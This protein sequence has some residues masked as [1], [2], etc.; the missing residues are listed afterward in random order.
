MTMYIR[1]INTIDDVSAAHWNELHDNRNPFVTHEFL[2]SLEREQCV[3]DDTGWEPR[4][5]I[6]EQEDQPVG[7]IPMYLKYHSMGEFVF[8]WAWAGAY[9]RSGLD[10]YPKLVIAIPYTPVTGPRLLLA[11]SPERNHIAE[12]MIDFALQYA[13][14]QEVSSMHWLF[15]NESDSQRLQRHGLLLRTDCQFHWKNAGYSSFDDFLSRLSSHKRKKLKRERRYVEEQGIRCEV[16][17]GDGIIPSHLD[18]FYEFYQS[19]FYKKG[20]IAPLTRGFFKALG[21]RLPRSVVLIFAYHDSQCV[22]GAFFMRGPD[23]LY[24]RYWGCKEEFHSLH[25]ELCYY[26]AID[27]CI[28]HGIKH[29]EAGAQGEHKLMRGFYPTQTRSLHWIAHPAFRRAIEDYLVHETHEIEFYMNQTEKHLP[30]KT[31]S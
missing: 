13:R 14:D 7:A 29:L 8:D 18:T 4:I 20:H 27:Y 31:G 2:S 22:A 17:K 3:G 24:G 5:I 28:A 19:T 26:R 6:A 21:K 23:T 25:F 16:I 12:A 15:P 11:D 10:Y 9:S 30:Y 1:I